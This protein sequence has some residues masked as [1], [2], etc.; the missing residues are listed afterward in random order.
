MG[1]NRELASWLVSRRREIE[2]HM[3]ERLGPAAPGAGDPES[4]A[5]RRFRTFASTA[6]LRGR[7]APPALDGLRPRERRVV[8]LLRAW[9]EA[10]ED[11]AGSRGPDVRRAL[12]PLV[13]QFRLSLRTTQ[14]S[15]R[16]R[17]APRAQRRAVIAAI[18]RVA[19]AFL[20]IDTES[21]E[22]ADANPAAGAL[23]GVDRDALLGVDA[24]SF[25][26]ADA[27]DQWWHE[28]DAAAESDEPRSFRGALQDKGG[29]S[30]PVDATITSFVTRGRTLALVLA[31][32]R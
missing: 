24:L 1:E 30:V 2:R 7:A 4:E 25:V 18:D 3:A 27:R 22:I 8:A 31:R 14:S 5:L 23:L 21:A 17:G 10:A 13:D 12:D 28:L 19:D 11:L 16:A 6:L 20:A 9:S 32:P 29:V 15:R 26:P